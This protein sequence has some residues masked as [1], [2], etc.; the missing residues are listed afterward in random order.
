M[1][2]G[3]ACTYLR[4]TDV[5]DTIRAVAEITTAANCMREGGA[6]LLIAYQKKLVS[7]PTLILSYACDK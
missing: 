4:I 3:C 1:R 5:M 2:G 7:C 6:K